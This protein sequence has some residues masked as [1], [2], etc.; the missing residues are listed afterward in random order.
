M[1]SACTTGFAVVL[2]LSRFLPAAIP[3]QTVTATAVGSIQT[4]SGKRT[5]ADYVQLPQEMLEQL[6]GNLTVHG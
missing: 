4:I 2:R 6:R 3:P 5:G 1:T